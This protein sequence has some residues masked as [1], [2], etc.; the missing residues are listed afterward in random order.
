MTGKRLVCREQSKIHGWIADFNMRFGFNNE[1]RK[2]HVEA[3]EL[4]QQVRVLAVQMIG[5]EYQSCKPI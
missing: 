2:E 5:H 4:S 3:R 1:D